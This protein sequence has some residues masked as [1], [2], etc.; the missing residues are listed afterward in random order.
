MVEALGQH[1][2]FIV[3]AKRNR[4]WAVAEIANHLN[5]GGTSEGLT[6]QDF[7]NALDELFL[8]QLSAQ[9]RIGDLRQLIAAKGI[10]RK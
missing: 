10:Q 1:G 9:V 5:S 4:A 8:E 2:W 6:D 7:I 3:A